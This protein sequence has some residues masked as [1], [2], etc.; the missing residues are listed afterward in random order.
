MDT[1]Q[2]G[3][4]TKGDAARGQVRTIAD[5]GETSDPTP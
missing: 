5:S 1:R 4:R 3:A 2:I